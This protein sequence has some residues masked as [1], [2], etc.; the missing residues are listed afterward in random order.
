[1]TITEILQPLDR[2]Q[3]EEIMSTML[4]GEW[5]ELFYLSGRYGLSLEEAEKLKYYG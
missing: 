2:Q 3:E 1:M 5:E 4:A